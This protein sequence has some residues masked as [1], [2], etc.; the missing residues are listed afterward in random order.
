MKSS[1]LAAAALAVL[2]LAPSCEKQPWDQVKVLHKHGKDAHGSGHG[3]AH[4]AADATENP[5]AGH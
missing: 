4:G 5:E 3:D 2:F 1:L